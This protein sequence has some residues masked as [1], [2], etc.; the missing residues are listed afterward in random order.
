MPMKEVLALISIKL[1]RCIHTMGETQC[2]VKGMDLDIDIG[3]CSR[4][5]MHVSSTNSADWFISPHPTA[6]RTT[7][8]EPHQQTIEPTQRK[9]ALPAQV[10][11]LCL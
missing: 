10:L 7:N 11:F 6:P 9:D 5:C 4:L 1:Y 3:R 8:K 2:G